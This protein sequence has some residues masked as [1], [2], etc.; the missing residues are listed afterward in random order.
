M[1]TR[2]PDTRHYELH[3]LRLKPTAARLSGLGNTSHEVILPFDW[4]PEGAD[5]MSSQPR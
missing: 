4:L 2:N 1:L 3:V 5:D